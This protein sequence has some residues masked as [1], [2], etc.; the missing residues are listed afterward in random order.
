MK[1]IPKYF[2]SYFLLFHLFVYADIKHSLPD[3][4]Q[5]SHQVFKISEEQVLPANFPTIHI[6]INEEPEKGYLFL[7]VWEDCDPYIMI[8]ENSGKPVYYKKVPGRSYDF[9][10]QPTGVLTHFIHDD[11][12]GFL[13][14][15]STYTVIDTIKGKNGYHIDE[16]ELQILPDGHALIIVYEGR[17]M[18]MSEIVE[19][20][21][22][23]ATVW[24]NHIQEL[25]ASGNLVFEWRCWDHFKLT[26]SA[27]DNLTDFHIDFT[28]TNAIDVDDDSHL[29]ISSRNLNEITKIH[30]KTGEIIW[31][32][33]GKNNEFYFVNDTI[34]FSHQHCIRSLGNH[35][36]LLFDNGNQHT[37]HFT[38]AV[39][40][41][42]DTTD[43]TATLVWQYRNEPDYQ[44]SHYGSVQRLPNGNTLM[45]YGFPGTPKA[46]EVRPDGS[47]VY[48][49]DFQEGGR[50]Y[51]TFKSEW[52]GKAAK[53]SLS[54]E[55]WPDK[56]R[57][58]FNQFG[59][60]TVAYYVVYTALE[61]D[62]YTPMDSTSNTYLDMQ[63]LENLR[64]YDFKVLSVQM[65][66]KR[67]EFSNQVQLFVNYHE[68]D[69]NVLANGNFADGE[70]GW[71]LYK[72]W[73][74]SVTGYVNDSETYY[75]NIDKGGFDLSDIQL[76][77]DHVS[78]VRG[79]KYRFEFDAYADSDRWINARIQNLTSINI[80]Y[81][82]TGVSLLNP[83]QQHYLYEFVMKHPTDF[84]A[85]VAFHCGQTAGEVW[86]DNVSLKE[87]SISDVEDE[88]NKSPESIQLYNNYPNPFNH[89][90]SIRY[91][92][93]ETGHVILTI[94][95][96]MG[97]EVLELVNTTHQAGSYHKRVHAS[98]L[99]S[100]IYFYRLSVRSFHSSVQYNR[101]RKMLL[102]K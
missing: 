64:T 63:S 38:R 67:S 32:L 23:F 12:E 7:S 57:L 14:M 78:L 36:Y 40:Y 10:V 65:D 73:N 41:E 77:Q 101:I 58:I 45:N 39:E 25:D 93:S 85:G 48:Q 88:K 102:I 51:R 66:G 17:R 18:N 4:N 2:L 80:N 47:I 68:P 34:G 84:N 91:S 21:Q 44:S 24:G 15:D 49:I 30:R 54:G 56:V 59:D 43:M 82:Q 16:H 74:T 3:V 20:G 61:D 86:I 90:T 46:L 69:S 87:I 52:H 71:D 26:D 94:F 5:P 95:N 8:L 37:P 22:T 99:S 35:H 79:R 62:R 9:K 76:F 83:V 100:G 81:S 29:L 31:R 70:A 11:I 27:V 53:P 42:L 6:S 33:G 50:S 19:G 28:H 60:S 55:S 97:E 1:W 75:L 89:E 13:V 96:V 92:I 98:Q 72:K